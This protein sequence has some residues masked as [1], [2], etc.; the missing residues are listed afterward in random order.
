MNTTKLKF[1]G[2]AVLCDTWQQ[3]QEL[4]RIAE[5][6]GYEKSMLFIED[7]FEDGDVY[8]EARAFL[9]NCWNVTDLTIIPFTQ[10]INQSDTPS[11]YGC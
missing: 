8:F 4:A 1:N 5:G 10:F 7:N 6:Q 11:V 2:V 3:M 9:Y